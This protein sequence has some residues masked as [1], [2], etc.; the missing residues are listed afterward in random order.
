[1]TNITLKGRDK[2]TQLTVLMLWLLLGVFVVYPL[3]RLLAMTF[4]A[5]GGFTLA[6]LKPFI[7]SWYDRQAAVN[8][9]LLGCAVG[10]AGTVLGFIFAFAVTRLAM[11]GWLKLVIGGVTILPLISP[12][13]T[14]SIALTLSLGPNG[15]LL[16][17]FWA[18]QLQFLRLLGNVYFRDAHVLSRGVYDAFDNPCA[19]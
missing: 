3:A 9:I 15:I 7:S 12:P 8:S 11:P 13:F 17:F 14:S 16:Q 18:R 4:W 19:H 10:A 1:M 5:D 2:T 6:N